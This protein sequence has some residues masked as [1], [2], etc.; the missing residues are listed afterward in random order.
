MTAAVVRALS[1]AGLATVAALVVPAPA[2]AQV[3]RGIGGFNLDT[4]ASLVS[5]RLVGPAGPVDLKLA[6]TH[7]TSGTGPAGQ[8]SASWLWPGDT[9]GNSLAALVGEQPEAYPVQ[10]SARHPAGPPEQK[11]ELAP[12]S[13]MSASSDASG[14]RA[15]V[16]L[17]GLT[18]PAQESAL[19]GLLA[20]PA[21]PP[22]P[23]VPV[24][25]GLAALM[26]AKAVTSMS[27]TSTAA[28]SVSAQSHTTA[29]SV[30]LLGGLVSIDGLD[31]RSVAT[32][33]GSAATADGGSTMAGVTI[34]GQRLPVDGAGAGVPKELT[35]TLAGLGISVATAPVTRTVQGASGTSR[36]RALTITVDTLPL[37]NGLAGLLAP[38]TG[39]LPADQ[40]APLLALAPQLVFVVGDAQAAA[41]AS[42]GS[43]PPGFNPVF[44]VFPS[45]PSI[46]YVPG[47]GLPV[48]PSSVSPQPAAPAPDKADVPVA[49][50][51]MPTLGSVPRALVMGALTFAAALGWALQRSGGFLMTRGGS[52]AHGLTTGVPDL[53]KGI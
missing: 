33:T 18:T 49:S 53:R 32:S 27:E 5:V 40:L 11:Q 30:T 9:A 12:G 16:G 38:V 31:V 20:P 3:P 34:A 37:R 46:P 47:S 2:P 45:F 48:P 39:L 7:A 8:A 10:V 25:P 52:C 42:P 1:V 41:N 24:S 4:Q 43:G 19:P 22:A 23:G 15:G 44:P 29:S 13:G 6:S 35:D 17:A 51:A 36:A 26:N 14:T 28:G 21:A 50:A